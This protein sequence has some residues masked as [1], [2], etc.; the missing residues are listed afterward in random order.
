[1]NNKLLA[2]FIFACIIF[3]P[4]KNYP[5]DVVKK[6]QLKIIPLNTDFRSNLPYYKVEKQASIEITISKDDTDDSILD[7]IDGL[8]SESESKIAEDYRIVF[9]VKKRPFG[10]CILYFNYFGDFL[11]KGKT[12]K[13]E[14]IKSFVFDLIP[15]IYKLE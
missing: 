10:K 8:T 1:M 12:Y 5:Q 13:N 2:T 15:E 14:K 6:M 4:L 7:M 3:I 11:Y 9:I